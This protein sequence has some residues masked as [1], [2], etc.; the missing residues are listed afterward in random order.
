MKFSGILAL[1]FVSLIPLQSHADETAVVLS[2]T[3]T[4]SAAGSTP[5]TCLLDPACIGSWAPGAADSGTDEGIYVQFEKPI[6][7]DYIE[8]GVPS[9]APHAD[10]MQNL[11][12]YLNGKTR[13]AQGGFGVGDEPG[14][15][16]GIGVLGKNS[17]S[18]TLVPMQEKAKSIYIKI[19][20]V[21][22]AQSGSIRIQSLRFMKKNA[23]GGLTAIPL[24][25]PKLIPAQ[26]SATS[27]LEPNSAYDPSNLFDSKY[28]F[29]WSTNGKK[30]DGRGESFTLSLQAPQNL[31]GIMLWNGYQRSDQH[32]KANG[33]VSELEIQAD[34]QAV[35]KIKIADQMDPQKIIFNPPLANASKLTFTIR[36]IIPGTTYKDVLISELRLIS[37]NGELITPTTTLP[38]VTAP[39]SFQALLN[40]SYASFMHQPVLNQEEAYFSPSYFCDNGRIRLRDNGTFVIYKDFNYGKADT[41]VR[42]ANINANVMEGNWEAQL[43]KVRIFGRRYV[44]ALQESEYMQTSKPSA[45][46]ATIFQSELV[47]KPYNAMTPAEKQALFAFLWGKKKGPLNK[48]QKLY[49]RLRTAGE[50]EITVEGSTYDDLIKKLDPVLQKL[51]PVYLSSSVLTDLLM[52]SDKVNPCW[53]PEVP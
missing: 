22:T 9:D 51:D 27:I 2:A 7:L 11:R 10:Y 43:D 42:P 29:A 49:W 20:P 30:N 5:I 24:T 46:R 38:K 1:V 3:A 31:S 48:A 40:R 15:N 25:L 6:D 36:D 28:D 26:I 44:T 8:L 45:P 23:T 32:Y 33:R 41:E 47:L 39:A 16:L 12:L 13:N 35:Q 19:D 53:A 14:G 37:A 18:G 52:P 50:G 21:V 34:A 4:S 17:A